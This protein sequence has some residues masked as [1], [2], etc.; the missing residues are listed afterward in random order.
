MSE[1]LRLQ[2][3]CVRWGDQTF[4]VRTDPEGVIAHLRKEVAELAARP[5][6]ASEH[7]DVL[8]LLLNAAHIAGLTATQLVDAAWDKLDVKPRPPRGA[9]RAHKLGLCSRTTP[10]PLAGLPR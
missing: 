3:E 1:I 4:G 8:I 6:A 9:S 5:F 10:P 7:A 2:K